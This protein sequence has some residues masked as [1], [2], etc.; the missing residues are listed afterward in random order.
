[1]LTDYIIPEI[2]QYTLNEYLDHT[3]IVNIQRL[4]P[5]LIFNTD[6]YIKIE[7]KEKGNF[8]EEDKY[9]D[10]NLVKS[11]KWYKDTFLCTKENEGRLIKTAEKNYLYGK[12]HGRFFMANIDGNL[13]LD[14]FY[15]NGLVEGKWIEQ[16]SGEGC[17]IGVLTICYYKNG[18]LHG[19][20]KRYKTK[21]FKYKQKDLFEEGTYKDG[22]KDG[23]FIKY[24]NKTKIEQLYVQDVLVET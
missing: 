21:Y 7:S 20:F 15:R 17:N 6:K 11:E 2:L 3:N 1:M 24:T 18:K 13:L 16:Q 5:T 10:G 14:G 9:I 19:P 8:L 12:F 23:I 4:S 22:L